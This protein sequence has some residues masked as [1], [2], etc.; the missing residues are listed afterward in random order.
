M[1]NFEYQ[2]RSHF[3]IES[4]IGQDREGGRVPKSDEE[5]ICVS[6]SHRKWAHCK[7]FRRGEKPRGYLWVSNYA[8]PRFRAPV[9]CRHY[10]PSNPLAVPLCDST[11]CAVADCN[12]SSF[13]SPFR[14]PKRATTA[15]PPPPRKKRTAKPKAQRQLEFESPPSFPGNSPT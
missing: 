12:C 10:D 6:C 11:S 13:V 3:D 1:A 7:K 2:P 8:Q 4:R 5:T 15:K 14:K 9:L